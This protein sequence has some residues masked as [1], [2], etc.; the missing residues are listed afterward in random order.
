MYKNIAFLFI[1]TCL[2]SCQPKLY[3]YELKSLANTSDSL[4]I[5]K[6]KN[7][8]NQLDAQDFSKG[9]FTSK[10][11][12]NIPYRLL[13]PKKIHAS[14]TFPLVITLHNSSRIGTDNENQLEPLARIWLKAAIRKKYPAFVLAPQFAA[15]STNY[16]YDAD[17]KI[18]VSRPTD[19]LLAITELIDSL[20]QQYPIKDIYLV[21]YSMGGSSVI[22]LLN[23]SPTLFTAAVA[24]SGVP[25]FDN[26]N[27]LQQLPIWLIHG[28]Q[29]L[30]NPFIGSEK[31]YEGLQSGQRVKFWQLENTTHHNIISPLILGDNIPRWLFSK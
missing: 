22:N 14:K 3:H 21:G 12:L 16:Q 7:D 11:H 26:I 27:K 15:R 25:Q 4:S 9:H 28:K 8:L 18:E 20:K 6:A 5:A 24:I 2:T 13:K 19:Q 23:Y 31:F 29:D 30:E 10:A 1:I 17:R